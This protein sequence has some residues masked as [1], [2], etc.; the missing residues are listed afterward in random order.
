MI[1]LK[2][3]LSNSKTKL[4]LFLIAPLLLQVL[5]SRA[6][7]QRISEQPAA[8]A[9]LDDQRS[10]DTELPQTRIAPD[11]AESIDEAT[12]RGNANKKERVIIQL[13]SAAAPSDVD[14]D[15]SISPQMQEE[16]FADKGRANEMRAPVMRSKIESMRGKF[17]RSLNNLGLISAD[18]RSGS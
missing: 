12:Q 14:E 1:V 13:R 15:Q 7:A 18:P 8:H 11:L 9:Q 3:L 2:R 17:K 10:V 4:V 16:R 5:P 6:T